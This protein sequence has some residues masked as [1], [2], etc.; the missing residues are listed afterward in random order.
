MGLYGLHHIILIMAH[1]P[2]QS[3]VRAGVRVRIQMRVG[4]VIIISQMRS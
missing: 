2:V 4:L 1:H 3:T